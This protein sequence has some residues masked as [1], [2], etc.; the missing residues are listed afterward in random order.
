MKPLQA[1][2]CCWHKWRRKDD[3]GIEVMESSFD[4]I[5]LRIWMYWVIYAWDYALTVTI[6]SYFDDCRFDTFVSKGLTVTSLI[7]II[8]TPMFPVPSF[9]PSMRSKRT[10]LSS[11]EQQPKR[12]YLVAKGGTGI[13]AAKVHRLRWLRQFKG[14][15]LCHRW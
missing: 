13:P 2:C 15:F 1:C 8:D 3:V 11:L 10:W 5:Q 9:R 14:P 12:I 4:F 7:H 6:P